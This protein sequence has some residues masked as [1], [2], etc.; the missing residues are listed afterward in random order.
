M[1]K[2]K[3]KTREAVMVYL[4]SRDRAL[5]ERLAK[6]TGLPRT[7]LLRRG[8]RHVA[9]LELSSESPGS[10]FEYLLETASDK[11]PADL[12]ERADDYLYGGGYREWFVREKPPAKKKRARVR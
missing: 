12:S 6:K 3:S 10:A 8:L 4:D 2:T 5:L 11:S 1:A 7:E 9:D